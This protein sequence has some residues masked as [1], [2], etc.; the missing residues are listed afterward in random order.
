MLLMRPVP[1]EIGGQDYG[2]K[3]I[4]EMYCS[5]SKLMKTMKHRIYIVWVELAS[6]MALHM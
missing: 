6:V 5:C 4:L 3:T 1:K 2:T